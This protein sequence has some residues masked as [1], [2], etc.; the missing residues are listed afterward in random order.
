MVPNE[1]RQAL[2]AMGFPRGRFGMYLRA[3]RGDTRIPSVRSNSLAIGSSP[4]DTLLKAISRMSVRSSVG[5]RGRLGRD[6]QRQNRRKPARCHP[7]KALG[8]TFT[9]ASFHAKPCESSTS[10]NRD[11]LSKRIGLTFRSW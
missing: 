2:I 5:I 8:V 6:F 4:Q 1:G 3:V 7:M 11:A 10:M 9:R